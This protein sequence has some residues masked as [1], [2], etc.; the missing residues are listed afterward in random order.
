MMVSEVGRTMSG[1]AGA[2]D[3]PVVGDHRAL[4]GEALH[5]RR[6]LLE[7]ALG[8]EEREVG[9]LVARRLEHAIELALDVLPDG[10]APRLDHHAPAHR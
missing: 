4:L 9:V 8:D 7:E 10:V 6:L 2:S 5:V 3:E 1:S